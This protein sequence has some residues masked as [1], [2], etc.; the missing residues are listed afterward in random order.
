MAKGRKR[1]GKQARHNKGNRFPKAIGDIIGCGSDA[2][3]V[4]SIDVGEQRFHTILLLNETVRD[5]I[6]QI[7]VRS[8][9]TTTQFVC[10]LFIAITNDHDS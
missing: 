5:L 7:E 1:C 10:T 9:L 2:A 4:F 6:A 3:K 8:T